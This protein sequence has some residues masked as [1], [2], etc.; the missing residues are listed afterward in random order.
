MFMLPTPNKTH[1]M[2]LNQG[3]STI[4]HRNSPLDRTIS[5]FDG[6]SMCPGLWVAK[7]YRVVNSHVTHTNQ[8]LD[9]RVSTPTVG[10]NDGSWSNVCGNYF[11]QHFSTSIFDYHCEN[12]PLGCSFNANYHPHPVD[13]MPFMILS[14]S[15][16]GF[17]DFNDYANATDDTRRLP[18]V[19][20]NQVWK[21]P[22]VVRDG[23]SAM[24]SHRCDGVTSQTDKPEVRET[25]NFVEWNSST[26][27][28]W[29]FPARGD[30]PS[31][32]TPMSVASTTSLE[33]DSS[34]QVLFNWQGSLR[35]VL[36]N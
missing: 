6:V 22:Y 5:S 24:S 35:P 4:T 13:A 27:K 10:N 36:V 25:K 2:T 18:N 8:I 14:L 19:M 20:R 9:A 17:I 7:T 26:L 30:N 1:Q 16:F 29:T 34:E 15:K 28:E 32:N 12:L 21:M 23:S 31:F 33:K 3:Y 11:G